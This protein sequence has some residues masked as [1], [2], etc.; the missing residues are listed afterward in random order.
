MW[1]AQSC[2]TPAPIRPFSAN[3]A[4][5]VRLARTAYFVPS[6]T[7]PPPTASKKSMF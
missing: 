6:I 3:V 5:H 4:V 7:E 2:G 1:V